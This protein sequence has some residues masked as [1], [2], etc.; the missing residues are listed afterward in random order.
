MPP[1]VRTKTEDEGDDERC[2][3]TGHA[4]EPGQAWCGRKVSS[5]EWAFVDA[6]HALL[7]TR[8]GTRIPVCAACKTALRKVLD[9]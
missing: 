6:T 7:A 1:E 4:A 3:L 8:N 9:A 2:V 5:M